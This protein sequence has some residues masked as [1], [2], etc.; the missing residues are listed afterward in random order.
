MKPYFETDLGKLYHGDCLEIMP[1]LQPVD[2]VITSPPYNLGNT[3]GG[4]FGDWSIW[5]SPPIS[6]GYG[7]CND[8]MPWDKYEKWQKKI[9]SCMWGTLRANGAIFYNHKPRL[10]NKILWTPLSLIGKHPLRQIII[11]HRGGCINFSPSHY[12]PSCEWIVVIAGP[13]FRL[14]NRSASKDGD[15]WG[16]SPDTKNSHPA[17]FPQ[18]LPHR[19][20]TT[21]VG[22]VVLDPFLGSG[23][24][25]VA[26]ERL[27]RKWIGIEIEEKYCEIAAKRIE[28]ENKQLKMF[29]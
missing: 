5:K 19:I 4:G 16:F 10:R 28:A 12:A 11:W 22:Q 1:Q 8:K 3:T 29:R 9:I 13:G 14:V 7:V 21:A 25:A 27:G 15:V 24:T 17:P 18:E 26:C 20:L 23:T 6:K 2:L